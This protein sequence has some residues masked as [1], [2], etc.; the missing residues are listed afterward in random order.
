MKYYFRV[1]VAIAFCFLSTISM[2]ISPINGKQPNAAIDV[3]GTIRVVYGQA[4]K[5][6][7]ITS[8]NHGQS[9]STPV[10]VAEVPNM[11]LGH[12]R[13][14]QIASSLHYSMITAMDKNG[15]I[16]S[17]KLDHSKNV[18]TTTSHVNDLK[19]SA[20][21]GLM[22]I[23]ADE[24]D[25]FF[26][27]WL[28]VRIAKL[29]NIFF[30]TYSNTGS[31][32]T[33][34]LVYRSP[35]GHVCEC[36]KPNISW[37]NNKIAITFR[38]WI[39]GSRDIYYSTSTNNG[40]TF[41]NAVQSGYGTWKLAGCPMDGGGSAVNDKGVLSAA[42]Q[43]NGE[44][45]YI[46]GKLA[47]RRIGAG[48]GVSMAQGSGNTYIGW[49]EDGTIRLYNLKSNKTIDLGKGSSASISILPDGKAFCV[50]EEGENIKYKL[51]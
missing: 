11:H 50:W 13:G 26:A 21:E 20:P 41:T 49:Q 36:C 4:A 25:H 16:H 23:T 39:N 3:N 51:S 38:N 48:R 43:R 31:W 33:N 9:F 19:G 15:E 42:W 22:S 27:V 14:P 24:H 44:V 37:N 10:L 29:N 34:K 28:D 18:W 8:K 17:F 7:C 30:S 46:N 12:T 2:A 1:F 45:F 5:I 32:K 35:E 6:Y 40:Q 47:E